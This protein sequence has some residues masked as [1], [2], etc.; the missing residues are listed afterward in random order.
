MV[1]TRLRFD[2][3]LLLVAALGTMYVLKIY[4]ENADQE[5]SSEAKEKIET[6]ESILFYVSMGIT[7][8]GALLYLGEKKIE[9]GSKFDYHKFFFGQVECKRSSPSVGTVK[10]FKAILS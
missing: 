6:T 10:A 1:S 8:L 4:K 7:L 5:L 3:W 2:M 9:Y